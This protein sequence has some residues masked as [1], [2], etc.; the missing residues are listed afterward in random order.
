MF[1]NL[2]N[3]AN[4][5]GLI[6]GFSL[7][8]LLTLTG[9]TKP[10]P[11]PDLAELL[12]YIPER[13]T[14]KDVPIIPQDD[15]Y[16]GPAALTTLVEFRGD[17]LRQQEA[18]NMVYTPGRKGTF[19]HDMVSAM[20]RLGYLATPVNTMND[21]MKE[22]AADNPVIIFQNL[23]FKWYP[24][25]HYSA[26]TGYEAAK[27]RLLVHGGNDRAVWQTVSLVGKT[28]RRAGFWGYTMVKVGDLP[29]TASETELLQAT[30]GLERAGLYEKAMQSYKVILTEFPNSS[31]AYL[32]MGN[33]EMLK[34]NFEAAEAHFRQA[35]LVD[36][37]DE[38]AVNNLAYSLHAQRRDAEACKL[39]EPYK[40]E[41]ESNLQDS[42]YQLCVYNK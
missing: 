14:I 7:F 25:W 38:N 32:G 4:E 23:A 1:K 28:W 41:H 27:G 42:Y 13:H 18:A 10:F 29:A 5:R 40:Q 17:D 2:M 37:S 8:V 35:T 21:A 11:Q 9:C 36:E 16:C 33:I 31:R 15:Y 12:P 20:Q 19:Q 24:Q 3:I 39:L 22:I 34:E 26:L 30:A 6:T